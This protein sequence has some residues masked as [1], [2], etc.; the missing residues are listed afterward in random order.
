MPE[1][2]ESGSPGCPPRCARRRSSM[3]GAIAA[4]RSG[5]MSRRLSAADR[6]SGAAVS[7]SSRRQI[8]SAR[9]MSGKS[10][11]TLPSSRPSSRPGRIVRC[12]RLF[13]RSGSSFSTARASRPNMTCASRGSSAENS[14]VTSLNFRSSAVCREST[15]GMSSSVRRRSM[16]ATSAGSSTSTTRSTSETVSSDCPGSRRTQPLSGGYM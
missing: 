7:R 10:R 11:S 16:L 13:R 8:D 3:S 14:S 4:R 12:R 9:S 2:V 6:T 1:S 15:P 5:V